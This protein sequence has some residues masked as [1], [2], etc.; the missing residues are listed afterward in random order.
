MKLIYCALI[1]LMLLPAARADEGM[2]QPGQLPALAEV[3]QERGLQIPA[4]SLND[5]SDYPM[6]AIVSL[7]NCPA[8]FVSPE[9]LVITNHHCIQK[10]LQHNSTPERNLIENGYLAENRA[11]ELSGGPGNRILVTVEV[12]DVS[13][14]MLDGLASEK[15]GL[16]R[17]STLQR[18]EK[19][20]IASCESE[21]G[22]RCAVHAFYEGL[23]YYLIRQLE[24]RDVRL[25]YAPSRNIGEFGGDIDNWMW[26]R[27]TGDYAFI[28]GYVAVD[29]SPTDF[30]LKNVAYSP[31]HY[32]T[33]S[34]DG[35]SKDDFAMVIGYPGRT[36]RHRLAAEADTIGSW[37]YPTRKKLYEK[38]LTTIERETIERGD[39]AIAYSSLVQSLNNI[40]KNYGGM[41]EGFSQSGLVA[42]KRQS[43]QQLAGQLSEDNAGSLSRL[44]ELITEYQ[45]GREHRMVYR[46]FL[47]RRAALLAAA[48]QLYRLS[49]EKEKA[50]EDREPGF[51]QR[52]WLRIREKMQA[53]NKRFDA[54][55]DRALFAQ[56]LRDYAALP[57]GQRV[58]ALDDWFAI[59]DA[60][61]NARD[62]AAK[63]DQM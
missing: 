11:D 37:Y 2:W 49:I 15:D 16:K 57:A 63:L 44:N 36:Y 45:Q 6:A 29:G 7:G 38:M 1:G 54:Q 13:K 25:V 61:I 39:A 59:N 55:V 26:P 4:A 27:H 50:D 56:H 46:D 42:R 40:I 12:R 53:L 20:L 47:R 58:A 24:I 62:L 60:E 28:R 48:S 35:L 21:N 23:E 41:I 32:L 52:D 33:V 17:F 9:G 5:L 34:T 22:F 10:I 3:L 18:R 51:Q 8:S 30:D 31:E 43:E 14:R 19:E